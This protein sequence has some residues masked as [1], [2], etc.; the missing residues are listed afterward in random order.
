MRSLSLNNQFSYF[1]FSLISFMLWSLLTVRYG[2][3]NNEISRQTIILFLALLILDL[4]LREITLQSLEKESTFLK[5]DLRPCC[6]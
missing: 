1:V 6:L 3:M 4:S 2:M 5:I